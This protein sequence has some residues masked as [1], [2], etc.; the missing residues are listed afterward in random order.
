[1]PAE[2]VNFTSK[3]GELYTRASIAI[4]IYIQC[5]KRVIP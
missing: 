2:T 4:L 1:M 3:L 5:F